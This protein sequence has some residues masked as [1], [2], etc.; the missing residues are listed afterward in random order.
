M[1]ALSQTMC[2]FDINY[3]EY[4]S[5]YTGTALYS[6]TSYYGVD[7]RAD[8]TVDFSATLGALYYSTSDYYEVSD[9]FICKHNLKNFSFVANTGSA[10]FTISS[11]VNNTLT[12]NYY[13]TGSVTANYYGLGVTFS[14]T[15]DGSAAYI[16]EL[17]M[18]RK[19][20]QLAINPS[21]YN[22]AMIDDGNFK[23]LYGGR[24]TYSTKGN[25]FSAEIE[26]KMLSGDDDPLLNSDLQYMTELSR[27]KT[28]FL[29]WPNANNDFM[30]MYT[31]NKH[32]IFKCRIVT[33][34]TS[35]ELAGGNLTNKIKARY[36]IE[37][38]Q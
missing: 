7:N 27:R 33:P 22:P 11:Y 3:L 1:V 34:Q 37:E 12:T 20:F 15:T 31:W 23:R 16:G 18:T 9:F 36:V 6:E 19:K 38:V 25:Y 13:S 10:W 32:H 8:V 26:W 28:T 21:S 17:I 29:F 24:S 5:S 35:Y 4:Y 2:F 30:N 14:A